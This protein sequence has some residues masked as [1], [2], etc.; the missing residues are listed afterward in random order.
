M[1]LGN[2][3][4]QSCFFLSL[5][6]SLLSMLTS[7]ATVAFVSKKR[8]IKIGLLM[9]IYLHS[10]EAF[11]RVNRAS[12][13]SDGCEFRALVIWLAVLLFLLFY[14]FCGVF[15]GL[16]ICECAQTQAQTQHRPFV[17]T[18][19]KRKEKKGIKISVSRVRVSSYHVRSQ[20]IGSH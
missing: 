15:P 9:S 12:V 6:F 18:I 16:Q 20:H 5:S 3:I 1:P 2:F 8:L 4:Y 7:L 10:R 13:C 19:K 17:Q 14:F 11:K